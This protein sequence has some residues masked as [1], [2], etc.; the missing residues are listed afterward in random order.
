MSRIK[1]SFAVLVLAAM[2]SYASNAQATTGP[3]KEVIA[4]GSSAMWQ[5]LALAAWNCQ[6][7]ATAP[8]FHYTSKSAFYVVDTRPTS[9]TLGGS[10]NLDQGPLWIVWDSTPASKGGPKVWADL[11]VDSVVGDRCY[12][13]SPRCY[14]NDNLPTGSA[15]PTASNNITFVWGADTTPPASVQA[16]F[17]GQGAQGTQVNAAA[18]DIRPEDAGFAICRVNSAV[19]QAAGGGTVNGFDATD[20]LGYNQT[21]PS[22]TCAPSVANGATLANLVGTPIQSAIDGGCPAGTCANVLAF[23]QPG[24]TDPFTG[25]AIP[26]ATTVSVGAVPVVFIY[27]NAGGQLAG[28]PGNVTQAQL[29]NVFSGTLCDASAFGL[30][31]NGIQVYLREPESGTM[32]T[33]EATVFRMPVNAPAHPTGLV[34]GMS[35]ETGVNANV[36]NPLTG[37]LACPDSNGDAN[38]GRWR[39]IGTGQEVSS[40]QKSFSANTWHSNAGQITDGIGYSFN[41]FG[42]FSNIAGNPA[43]GYV[44]VD[45]I[46][47]IFATHPANNELPACAYPCSEAAIWGSFGTSYP[48]V[49]N[50]TYGAWSVVRIVTASSGATLTAVKQLVTASQNFA[51]LDVPDYVPATAAAG[52]P[53]LLVWRSHYQ[54]WDGTGATIGS[55]PSNCTFNAGGNPTGGDK[56][57]DMGGCVLVPGLTLKTKTGYIQS[58]FGQTG[59]PGAKKGSISTS[60]PVRKD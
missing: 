13:A 23:N 36:N 50:G 25:A 60:C 33:T 53:G 57:G 44:S 41:G 6:A 56:G 43:Y 11:K 34:Y 51:V 22:G 14:I 35:Q 10:N 4:S 31:N 40:V 38:G 5:T 12:L 37:A 28:M 45:G 54:Q 42:N 32:N 3:T 2:V 29:Q 15:F 16:L 48:N 24:G 52:D 20:G 7:P 1:I 19:G 18:T 26:A 39:T 59:V 27:G 8:C 9:G 55:A 49:R 58:S 21:N 17:T 46:D 47:P 30:A